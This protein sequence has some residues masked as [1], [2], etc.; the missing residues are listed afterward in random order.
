MINQVGGV[1]VAQSVRNLLLVLLLTILAS[2]LGL[3]QILPIKLLM[4]IHE[5]ELPPAELTLSPVHNASC[6]SP[7]ASNKISVLAQVFTHDHVTRLVPQLTIRA[8]LL[9]PRPEA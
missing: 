8:M 7:C 2:E 4:S 9:L 3:G 5:V 6:L 1:I